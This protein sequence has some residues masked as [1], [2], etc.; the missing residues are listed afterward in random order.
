MDAPETQL[1]ELLL[2]GTQEVDSVAA[3]AHSVA[4][5]LFLAA[6]LGCTAPG[7][8]ADHDAEAFDVLADFVALEAIGELTALAFSLTAA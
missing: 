8:A 3:R 7:L 5:D 6:Q 1:L 4:S 2:V